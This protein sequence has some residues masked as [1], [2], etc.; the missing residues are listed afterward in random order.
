MEPMSGYPSRD[1]SRPLVVLAVLVAVAV[2]G[3]VGV[4]YFLLR[5]T[6]PPP[7]TL[8]SASQGIQG[9][10]TGTTGIAPGSAA[11]S[12]T[13]KVDQTVSSASGGSFGGFRVKEVLSRGIGSADAVGTSKALTG[14]LALEGNTLQSGEFKVDLTKLTTDR[15]QR[16]G[17]M[18]RALE[19]SKYPEATFKV[20]SPV[21]LGKAP[22]EG[23]TL[24]AE[25]PGEFTIHGTT[26]EAK[27]KVDATVKGGV[28]VIT[29]SSP[30]T[31]AE[32]NI[33]KPTSPM[34]VSLEDNGTIELQL[35]LTRSG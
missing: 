7:P 6:S 14:T 16:E 21:D 13:W 4:W 12:G 31:F 27:V 26:R 33:T 29:G 19:T 11:G 1:R 22:V 25:V 28:L 9:G 5:D 17:P 3:G 8:S 20:K 2:A 10:S 15:Q 32:Y 30:F 35:Y 34:V 24:S 23:A 18:N